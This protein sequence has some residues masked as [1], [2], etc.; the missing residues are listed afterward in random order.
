MKKCDFLFCLGVLLLG[1]P[2]AVMADT[3]AQILAR[4]QADAGGAASVERGRQLYHGKFPG[5]KAESCSSCHTANPKEG[6]R[7]VRTNKAIE[8]LAPSANPERFTDMAKVEKWFK[9]N[10]NEVLN[11][12]CTPQEKADFAAYVLSVK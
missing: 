11:R 7:H 8:P 1:T 12:A 3:P 5:E 9:R 2:L 4:L 10:C 6:G